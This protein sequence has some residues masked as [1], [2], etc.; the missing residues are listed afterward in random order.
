MP[1]S[2]YG[3][4]IVVPNLARFVQEK[5]RQFAPIAFQYPSGKQIAFLL[6]E[7]LTFQAY[8]IIAANNQTSLS[9]K[10]Q[11]QIQD[12]IVKMKQKS[13]VAM[14]QASQLLA[15]TPPQFK[16]AIMRMG[17]LEFMK[18]QLRTVN[19]ILSVERMLNFFGIRKDPK[20]FV[21]YEK[22]TYHPQTATSIRPTVANG[23]ISSVP[24]DPT[25]TNIWEQESVSTA[26]SSTLPNGEAT[27]DEIAFQTLPS[28]AT[29]SV[30]S[31]PLPTLSDGPA[32]YETSETIAS[33]GLTP[34]SY[35]EGVIDGDLVD[36]IFA[37]AE[38]E[39]YTTL[40]PSIGKPVKPPLYR[41]PAFIGL[42]ALVILSGGYYIY[43]SNQ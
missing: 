18:S 19:A 42:A 22:K 27:G 15:Q 12:T 1:N 17:E 30:S 40:V 14:K 37:E 2:S 20:G 9:S 26:Q 32:L 5:E 23:Q 7:A 4:D 33:Q 11:Q 29:P 21:A 6:R 41:R 25:Y 16:E 43:R 39:D 34:A 13:D 10:D 36:A 35:D 24:A 31:E 8:A 38:E 28:T 3:F